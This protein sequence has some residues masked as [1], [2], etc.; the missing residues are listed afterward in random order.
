[1]AFRSQRVVP[2]RGGGSFPVLTQFENVLGERLQYAAAC[3]RFSNLGVSC[4][5]G[6]AEA[7]CETIFELMA[8]MASQCKA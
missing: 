4:R 7:T 5:L 1:M 3:R 6:G 2:E 8:E